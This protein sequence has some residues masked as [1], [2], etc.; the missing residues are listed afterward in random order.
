MS[1][2]INHIGVTVPD[3]RAAVTWYTDVFDLRC[4]MGPRVLRAHSKVTAETAHILGPGFKVAYQAHMLDP[5]GVGI[6]LFQFVEPPTEAREDGLGWSHRGPWHLCFTVANIH[7]QVRR[8]VAAGGEQ[9]CE[10]T[11]FVPG[12]SWQLVYLRD[13]WGTV[14]ELMNASYEQ[15][16]S[17]WPQPGSLGQTEW[18]ALGRLD[19]TERNNG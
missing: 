10:V 16:F 18:M 19:G 3:I 13:P 11:S 6:E 14:L 15:V 12:Q 8:V 4:I 2:A 17:G 7:E 5:N 1:I 9:V